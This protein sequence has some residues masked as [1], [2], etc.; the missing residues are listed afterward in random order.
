MIAVRRA[1]EEQGRVVGK[2]LSRRL[3]HD[4]SEFVGLDPV[5]GVEDQSAARFQHAPRLRVSGDAIGKEH[6]TELATDNVETV[7][8]EGQ[9]QGIRRAPFDTRVRALNPRRPIEHRLVEVC[10]DITRVCL[11]QRRQCARHDA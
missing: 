9:R 2:D 8:I 6:H 5:P 3:C 7:V 1:R 11:K 10:H 4:I